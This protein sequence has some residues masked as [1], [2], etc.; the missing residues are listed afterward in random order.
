MIIEEFD[1][2]QGLPKSCPPVVE[3]SRISDEIA[4]LYLLH[5]VSTGVKVESP[6]K[7]GYDVYLL[8]KQL[9][10]KVPV[11]PMVLSSFFFAHGQQLFVAA[12]AHDVPPDAQH[13]VSAILADR[14]VP[15]TELVYTIDGLA[16]WN[17]LVALDLSSKMGAAFTGV[18]VS[19]KCEFTPPLPMGITVR[20]CNDNV[21]Q[22][23]V[24]KFSSHRVALVTPIMSYRGSWAITSRLEVFVK[25]ERSAPL[26]TEGFSSASD[27][28]GYNRHGPHHGATSDVRGYNRHGP[29][30]GATSDNQGF[31]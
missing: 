30:H 4:S 15:D 6:F 12:N 18:L 19:N 28:R 22:D 8:P 17:I 24:L 11:N 16:S 27:F 26:G 13:M 31:L 10:E 2:D 3:G 25:T 9:V 14:V 1:D 29:Q 7:G 20:S 21:L 23:G 5:A